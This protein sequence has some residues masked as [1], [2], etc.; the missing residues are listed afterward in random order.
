MDTREKFIECAHF[1][2]K[3]SSVKWEFGYWGKTLNNWYCEGLPLNNYPVVPVNIVNSTASLYTAV[4]R[5]FLKKD[6]NLFEKMFNQPD[7]V[8]LPDGMPVCAG[9]L[10]WPTQG[11]AVDKDVKNYFK[12]DE[13][14]IIVCA[15][16]LFYPQFETKIIFEDEK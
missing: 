11:F 7:G 2:Q 16:Q 15:E 12:M 3:A 8:K 10:Y 14:Q 4:W 13:V 5:H 6:K 1:K 9:G